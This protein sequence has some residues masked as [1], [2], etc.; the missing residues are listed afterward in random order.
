MVEVTFQ[1]DSS[2]VVYELKSQ[3]RLGSGLGKL[4][5]KFTWDVSDL[6]TVPYVEIWNDQIC[7]L[8]WIS[9]NLPRVSR[10]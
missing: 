3:R 7:I 10:K 8:V 5:K 6:R 2:L 1:T 9:L 4:G